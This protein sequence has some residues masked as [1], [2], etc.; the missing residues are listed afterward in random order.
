M[1][2][3][4][5]KLSIEY[6]VPFMSLLYCNQLNHSVAIVN[7]SIDNYSIMFQLLL[8][9]ISCEVHGTIL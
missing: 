2:L 6:N 5:E 3:H 8:T 4:G 9:L 1:E 7:L